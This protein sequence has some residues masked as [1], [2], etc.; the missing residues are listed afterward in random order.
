MDLDFSHLTDD[1]LIEL[2]RFCCQEAIRRGEAAGTAMRSMMIDEAERARIMRAASET[3]A[4]AIRARERERIAKEAAD[5]V[6]AEA[7]A[8]NAVSVQKA[9]EDAGRHAAEKARK[10]TEAAMTWLRR[11]AAV[12]EHH[13]SEI[14]VSLACTQYGRRV[15]VNLGCDRY[16]REH[17]VDHNISKNVTKTTRTLMKRKPDIAALAAEF[18]VIHATGS[19][20]LCGADYDWGDK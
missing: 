8:K 17:L 12:V 14:S 16:A 2:V 13:P 3:E 4:A 5:R 9:A 20:H 15:L 19:L 7:T 18:G 6:R 1:Q 10:E 11:F